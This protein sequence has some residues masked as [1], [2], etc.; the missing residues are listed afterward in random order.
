[1]LNKEESMR[2][3]IS[4]AVIVVVLL[5]VQ[6]HLA[7]RAQGQFLANGLLLPVPVPAD[8]PQT[9][10]KIRL[11]RQLYFDARLSSD[12]TI[13]CAS[14]HK[15]DKAWADTGPKSEG[16]AHKLGG[17]NSPTIINAAYSVPQFWDGRAMHL[18]KQA[19][20]PVQNP[21]EMDLTM[22]LL[23]ARLGAIPGYVEQFQQVF[24]TKPTEQTVAK[25]IASF[26]RTVIC[27]DSPYD[28]YMQGDKSAMM[29]AAVRGMNL[30]TG[31]AHCST[32]HSG[33]YFGDSR[34]HNL[35]I[36]YANGKFADVGRFAVTKNVKDMGAFKT[37]GLR[38]VAL[39]PP[40]LHDGSERTLM[41]VIDLYNRGGVP[42]PSLDRLMMPL[43][44]TRQEKC[45]LVAFLQA[46]TGTYPIDG[47]PA[48]PNPELTVKRLSEILGGTK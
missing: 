47:P 15:P 44:L 41:D 16:V 3:L 35:G 30:F 23:E 27:N 4:A 7:P 48:L 33:P 21:V 25:A 12:G 9:D 17:R 32:C 11:G 42:N 13:S 10:A 22:Q 26:E 37:P 20:G 1:L 29:P 24:G 14:C 31:K 19:V 39:T 34:Y 18:E 28:K 40:Y 6:H 2:K 45:D 8:N 5:A 36:G 46:L 43:N 38:C